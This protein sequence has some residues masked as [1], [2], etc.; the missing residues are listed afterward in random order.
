VPTVAVVGRPE[1]SGV[2]SAPLTVIVALAVLLAGMPSLVAPVVP[3]TADAPVAVGVPET[4]QV[5]LAPAASEA[6][7]TVGTQPVTVTPGGSP[8]T[9]HVALVAGSDGDAAAVHV[10]V[11][12]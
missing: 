3:F 7:G 8:E 9:A 1:T 5:M 4:E 10:K 2:M 6:T 12:E 11:P